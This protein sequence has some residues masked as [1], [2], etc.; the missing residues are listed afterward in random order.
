MNPIEFPLLLP[1]M[2]GKVPQTGHDALLIVES[3]TYDELHSQISKTIPTLLT[4]LEFMVR[5]IVLQE[6]RPHDIT[7]YVLGQQ[8][9]VLSL[10]LC[11]HLLKIDPMVINRGTYVT[12]Q[13]GFMAQSYRS[14]E[15]LFQFLKVKI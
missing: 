4:N 3:I 6:A 11:M 14:V 5:T 9:R 7:H 13:R 10:D 15:E 2:K 1:N 12:K 8:D